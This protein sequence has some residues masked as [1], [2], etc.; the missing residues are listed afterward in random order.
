MSSLQLILKINS[1]KNKKM[2]KW[3]RDLIPKRINFEN[4]L[5]ILDSNVKIIIVENQL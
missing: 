1:G 4:R 5:V 2:T 3:S